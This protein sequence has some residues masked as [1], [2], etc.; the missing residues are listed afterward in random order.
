MRRGIAALAVCASLVSAQST[1]SI[2]IDA[3]SVAIPTTVFNLPV[4]YVTA[5]DAPTVTAT[6]LASSAIPSSDPSATNVFDSP[7][8]VTAALSSASELAAATSS[9]AVDKR[10]ASSCV[11]QPTGI[12]YAVQPDTAAGWVADTHFPSVAS[13][14]SAAV[15]AG[16]VSSFVGLTASNSADGYA[17]FTLMDSYDVAGCAAKCNAISSCKSFNIYFERDPSVNP[18]D[19]T[20]SDPASY[21]QVKCVYWQGAVTTDNANNFGQ[22]RNQFQVLIA[23]SNGYINSA[24]AAALASGKVPSDAIAPTSQESS[25]QSTYDIYSGYDSNVG[26]Y[27]NAQASKSYQDCETA[28][29][30]DSSCNAFTYVGGANGVGSGTCWLKQK[31]GKPTSAGTNVVTGSK[32]GKINVLTIISAFYDD[33]DV[34]NTVKGFKS[35]NNININTANMV[36][37]FGSDPYSGQQKALS[38]LFSNGTATRVFIATD[39]TGSYTLAPGGSNSAPNVVDTYVAPNTASSSV[40]S[41]VY[42]KAQLTSQNTYNTYNGYLSAHNQF[43]IG[44]GEMGV[45]TWPGVRKTGI[46]WYTTGGSIFAKAFREYSYYTF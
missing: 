8:D 44:N 39:N 22:W 33:L 19:T 15:P 25:S 1:T 43:Y 45:D 16:Y 27:S 28:C 10:A 13:A 12:N 29:D 9:A 14:A 30:A 21:V 38:I 46:F 34:T 24:Y 36:S 20:C 32:T 5:E 17:G 3:I 6:T 18:D 42:G 11:P 41:I 40:F 2:D 7:A 26:A 37:Q 31:L 35:G 4:V 23:G